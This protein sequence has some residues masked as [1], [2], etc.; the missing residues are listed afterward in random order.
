MGVSG[1]GGWVGSIDS[2]Y[3]NCKVM[4]LSRRIANCRHSRNLFSV[5]LCYRHC[6]LLSTDEKCN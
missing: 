1:G 3:T 6:Y 4:K 5:A 2:N